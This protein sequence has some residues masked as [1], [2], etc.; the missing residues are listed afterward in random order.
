MTNKRKKKRQRNKSSPQILLSPKGYR[1]S[2]SAPETITKITD[3]IVDSE[4]TVS[5]ELSLSELPDL[6]E[7]ESESESGELLLG[8]NMDSQ[9][10]QSNLGE[11]YGA[12]GFH[13]NDDPSSQ[14]QFHGDSRLNP[15]QSG[16]GFFHS[17][18]LQQNMNM[19]FQQPQM[20]AI[21]NMGIWLTLH[22][23]C[24][25]YNRCSNFPI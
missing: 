6:P 16:P 19:N 5:K 20:P 25:C 11:S 23:P 9:E 4:T 7:T 3:N 14:S 2:A 21:A 22:I 12:L 1:Q 18:S 13:S 8:T 17:Q 15:G 24:K 10:T